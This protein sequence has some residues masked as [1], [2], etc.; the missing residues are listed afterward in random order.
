MTSP[1]D[2]IP[3]TERWE[4]LRRPETGGEGINVGRIERLVSGLAG[5]G[6]IAVA[7]RRRRLRGALLPLGGS[8]IAR[9]VT[10]RCPVNR[11]LGR[12]S[13]RRDATPVGGGVGPGEGLRVEQSVT[14]DRP[15]GELFRFWRNFENLPRFM[16][17]LESVTVLN[18]Q[19]SHWVAKGPVGS[20]VAWDAEIYNEIEDELIAWRS[21]PGSDVAHAGSAHFTPISNS[22]SEVRVVLRYNPPAGKLG[23]AF[24]G[25]FGEEPTRQ[26]ADDLRRLKQVMEAGEG[27]PA[28]S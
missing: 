2:G 7:L 15:A 26:V 8:L 18:S 24:A 3:G 11:A 6:L 20:R 22:S 5:A 28:A 13:A 10:G 4:N 25:L 23:A 12:N 17:H 16:D 21:L 19:H 9:A 27:A 14:I 1:Y